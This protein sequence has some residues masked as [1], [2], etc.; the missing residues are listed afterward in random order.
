MNALEQIEALQLE[1]QMLREVNE[2]D[3]LRIES[4][5]RQL[6]WKYSENLWLWEQVKTQQNHIWKYLKVIERLKNLILPSN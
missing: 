2:R 5:H 4:L 3:E 6:E 1:L